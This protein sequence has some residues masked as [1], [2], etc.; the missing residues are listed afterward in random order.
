VLEIARDKSGFMYLEESFPILKA[1]VLELKAK[2]RQRSVCEVTTISLIKI[3][4]F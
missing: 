3:G 4:N 2:K 1:V